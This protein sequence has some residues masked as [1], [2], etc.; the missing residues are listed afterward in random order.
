MRQMGDGAVIRTVSTPAR[1]VDAA[2]QEPRF[3]RD[4]V[5]GEAEPGLEEPVGEVVAHRDRRGHL[6]GTGRVVVEGQA[7][8]GLRKH[9]RGLRVAR[10][11]ATHLGLHASATALA[12][13][14]HREP[15]LLPALLAWALPLGG[16][17]HG[18][19]AG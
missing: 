10:V 9:H 5:D 18:D 2:F 7:Q 1:T 6:T 17:A 11:A 12:D 13:E 16:P 15:G 4:A 19:A 8:G 3:S 14:A